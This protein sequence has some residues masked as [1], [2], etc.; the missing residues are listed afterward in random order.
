M[1]CYDHIWLSYNYENLK[2]EKIAFKV[3]QMKFFAMY[4]TNQ[5]WFF[6]YLR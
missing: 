6:L 5:K 4:I 1:V 2:S 3:I